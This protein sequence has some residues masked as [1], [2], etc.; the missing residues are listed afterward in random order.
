M[1]RSRPLAAAQPS[2]EC[3]SMA[4]LERP[5]VAMED[6]TRFAVTAIV[7]AA[8]RQHQLHLLLNPHLQQQRHHS[9]SGQ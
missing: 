2:E 8:P 5:A 7:V 9:T 3:V 6:A 4:L 1:Q